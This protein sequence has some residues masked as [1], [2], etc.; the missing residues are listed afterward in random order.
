MSGKGQEKAIDVDALPDLD[1]EQL[2]RTVQ[3]DPEEK[4]QLREVYRGDLQDLE[5]EHPARFL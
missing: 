5:G 3:Q 4:R 2:L 1:V